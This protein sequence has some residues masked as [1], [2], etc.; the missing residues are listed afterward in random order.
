MQ[1]FLKPHCWGGRPPC[2]WIS[3]RRIFAECP[4][5]NPERSRTLAVT[6]AWVESLQ[7]QRTSSVNTDLPAF[8]DE[9]IVQ[10]KSLTVSDGSKDV[11]SIDGTILRDTPKRGGRFVERRPGADVRK[12]R[13]FGRTNGP[14]FPACSQEGRCRRGRRVRCVSDFGV[15]DR[16][17]W[18]GSRVSAL[19]I[20]S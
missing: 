1:K 3:L 16:P 6:D 15:H 8:A 13:S 9:L 18:H 11:N 2:T 20:Q 17:G 7:R 10:L 14:H 19:D 5:C 4:K 12:P